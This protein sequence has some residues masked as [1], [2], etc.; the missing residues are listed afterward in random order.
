MPVAGGMLHLRGD[1]SAG[2]AAGTVRGAVGNIPF[3]P[4]PDNAPNRCSCDLGKVTQMT[5]SS[6]NQ[7]VKLCRSQVVCFTYAEILALAPQQAQSEARLAMSRPWD[8]CPHTEPTLAGADMWG[9]FFPSDLPNLY[10]SLP[11]YRSEGRKAYRQL[12]T[13]SRCRY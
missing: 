10:T 3:W 5:L 2:S 4:P 6:R 9:L 11:Q 12:R 1:T 7:Q 13:G 8:V